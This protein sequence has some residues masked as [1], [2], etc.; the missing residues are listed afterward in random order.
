[1]YPSDESIIKSTRY[2]IGNR[3]FG[4]TYVIKD[5]FVFGIRR[6]IDG[7]DTNEYEDN[8]K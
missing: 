3:S 6:V 1:M 2:F 7:I 5:N 4:K 8:D